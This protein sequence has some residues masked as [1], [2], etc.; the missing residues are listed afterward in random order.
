MLLHTFKVLNS[1]HKDTHFC[2]SQTIFCFRCPLKTHLFSWKCYSIEFKCIS[3]IIYLYFTSFTVYFLWIKMTRRCSQQSS[4]KQN[5]VHAALFF[6]LS[7]LQPSFFFQLH[8]QKGSFCLVGTDLFQ[9]NWKNKIHRGFPGS[10]DSHAHSKKL[11]LPDP[12]PIHLQAADT[13]TW[14]VLFYSLVPCLNS[15]CN[16]FFVM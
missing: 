10:Y 7:I 5:T 15:L 1:F 9:R 2:H 16:F 14:I 12:V 11:G 6:S 3:N 13:N 4:S 8:R